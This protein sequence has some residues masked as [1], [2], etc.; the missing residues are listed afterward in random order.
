MR[1]NGALNVDV[2][3]FHRTVMV[4][5]PTTL[6]LSTRIFTVSMDARPC[7]AFAA[8]LGLRAEPLARAG[9]PH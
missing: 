9:I 4:L 3:E 8:K 7:R 5:L 6:C 2:T 1:L